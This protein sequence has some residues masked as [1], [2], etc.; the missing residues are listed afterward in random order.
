MSE[1][2]VLQAKCENFHE[3]INEIKATVKDLVEM[4][5]LQFILEISKDL[6][7]F[8]KTDY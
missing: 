3:F 5:E 7:K 1:N 4:K 6:P 8:F 2:L